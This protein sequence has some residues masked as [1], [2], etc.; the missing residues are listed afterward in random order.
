MSNTYIVFG[1]PGTGKTHYLVSRIIDIIKEDKDMLNNITY[2]TFTKTAANEAKERIYKEL[3]IS[4]SEIPWTFSTFHSVCYN[5]LG[6][7]RDMVVQL[8]HKKKFCEDYN[9]QFEEYCSTEDDVVTGFDEL[10]LG[11]Q[12]FAIYDMFKMKYPSTS[13]ESILSNSYSLLN[14]SYNIPLDDNSLISFWNNWEEYKSEN[15]LLDFSDMLQFCINEHLSP[16]TEVFIVDE[17]QDMYPLQYALYSLWKK[18]ADTIYMAGDDWQTIYDCFGA[19]ARFL[20]NEKGEKIILP[21][22]Y[23]LKSNIWNFSKSLI[24]QVKNQQ[25]K[26]IT[27]EKGGKVEFINI[28][29]IYNLVHLIKG[30]TFMLFR[31][32]Y[33]VK[34]VAHQLIE[35][36]IPFLALRGWT[37]WSKKLI[38]F[39]NSLL[40]IMKKKQLS[41]SEVNNILSF[42]PVK[43]ILRRGIKSKIKKASYDTLTYTEF[44]KLFK[45]PHLVSI[46][47]IIHNSK[48]SKVQR[49]ALNRMIY[50]SN[51]YSRKKIDRINLYIGTIHSSKGKEA[52]NVIL[53]DNITYKIHNEL[54]NNI[55]SE[56]R[57]FFTA[58]TRAINN[59]YIVN[60][61]FNT[62]TFSN[63]R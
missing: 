13:I 12:L 55:D 32:N 2:C 59:L 51:I 30:K 24:S 39:Y 44:T 35:A 3:G 37:V 42:I 10:A 47:Y 29:S 17:A 45:Y 6:L 34:Q 48:L 46:D 54:F 20:L 61:Y 23:R 57:V 5:L 60:N 62:F 50:N 16:D 14:T 31:T 49:I 41:I 15:N 40:N 58:T 56:V 36:G 1:A 53:F 38:D 43:N 26:D 9:I 7:K 11:N 8:K 19:S 28:N 18:D 52:N 25:K 27:C 63:W 33:M 22:S 21:K 4:Y